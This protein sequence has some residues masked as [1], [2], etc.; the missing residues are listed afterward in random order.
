MLLCRGYIVLISNGEPHGKRHPNPKESI[1]NNTKK[2]GSNRHNIARKVV[3]LRTKELLS[4][5][6]I[7]DM[8]EISPKLARNLFQERIGTHQHHDHLPTKGGRFPA[9]WTTEAEMPFLA[10]DGSTNQW[11]KTYGADLANQD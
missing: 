7:A 4:W 6:A 2:F 11:E 10:G 9:W 5:Q 3:R 8:L 1:M